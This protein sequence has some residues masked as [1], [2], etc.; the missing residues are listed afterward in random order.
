[1]AGRIVEGVLQH[2]QVDLGAC[3]FSEALN[4]LN[5]LSEAMNISFF[6]SLTLMN[7]LEDILAVL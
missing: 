4:C 1:V 7:L 2:L 3:K 6:N 5:F